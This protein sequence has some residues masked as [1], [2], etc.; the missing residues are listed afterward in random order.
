[1]GGSPSRASPRSGHERPAAVRARRITLAALCAALVHGPSGGVTSRYGLAAVGVVPPAQPPKGSGSI[2]EAQQSARG[3]LR[4]DL[5]RRAHE[6][7][8]LEVSVNSAQQRRVLGQRATRAQT[9][10]GGR[11]ASVVSEPDSDV[12]SRG[13]AGGSRNVKRAHKAPRWFNELQGLGLEADSSTYTALIDTA[14]RSG[15]L[16]EGRRWLEKATQDGASLDRDSVRAFLEGAAGRE[17]LVATKFW[18]DQSLASGMPLSDTAANAAVFLIAKKEGM[19]MVKTMLSQADLD[20]STWLRGEAAMMNGLIRRVMNGNVPSFGS[21]ERMYEEC[22]S[23]GVEPDGDTFRILITEAVNLGE[24]KLAARWFGRSVER[25]VLPHVSTLNA[26]IGEAARVSGLARAEHWFEKARAAGLAPNVYTFKYMIQ[27]ATKDSD[28][29]APERWYNRSIDMGVAPDTVTFNT[30][31][32]AAAKRGRLGEAEGWFEVASAAGVQPDTVTFNTLIAAA[33]RPPLRDLAAGLK[34]F[35]R[36][37]EAGL[38][39]DVVTFNTVMSA[40]MK[41]ARTALVEDLFRQMQERDVE[42]DAVTMKTMRW[43]LGRTRVQELLRDLEVSGGAAK[44][45]TVVAGR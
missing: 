38:D 30:L 20:P 7:I 26:I 3:S 43:A 8:Q 14:V 32:N 24:L 15:D 41:S 23:A 31:I 28:E 6:E 2:G 34:W 27:A 5:R 33:V 10:D 39:Y 42:P 4:D 37:G 11:M 13:G 18:L 16:E 44:P 9:Q 1:M 45:S 36:L 25:G 35:E 22:L 19:A 21:A 17:D 12:A 40:A 29:Q